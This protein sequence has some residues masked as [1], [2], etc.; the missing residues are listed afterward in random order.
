MR[1]GR[2]ILA[3]T[4]LLA[5][6]GAADALAAAGSYEAHAR[7]P[8]YDSAALALVGTGSYRTA[9]RHDE[10]K[11]TVCLRKRTAGRFFDVRCETATGAG[12]K[13]KAQVSVPG[14]VAGVWRTRATGET[15]GRSG[16]WI[17]QAVAVSKPFRC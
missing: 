3:I 4:L 1:N 10:L 17:N 9:R 13:V 5:A 2:Y 6:L 14:C 16:E 8:A 12:K 7:R 15:R 11:V